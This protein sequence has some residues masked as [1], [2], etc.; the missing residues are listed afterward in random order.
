MAVWNDNPILNASKARY[1]QQPQEART[2]EGEASAGGR[3][4]C[5]GRRGEAQNGSISP[6][7]SSAELDVSL[8]RAGNCRSHLR[9]LLRPLHLSRQQAA[10]SDERLRSGS[11][12]D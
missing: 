4:G 6:L 3:N 1:E 5:C 11:E 8:R 7:N 10:L 2:R 9:F 12:G